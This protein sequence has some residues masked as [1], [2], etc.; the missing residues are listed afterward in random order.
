LRNYIFSEGWKD[1]NKE[2]DED[3]YQEYKEKNEKRVD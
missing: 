3:H 1:N 2:L